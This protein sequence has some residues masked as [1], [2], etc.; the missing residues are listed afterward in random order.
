M[1]LRVQGASEN[2]VNKWAD[3]L[4][5]GTIREAVIEPVGIP[6]FPNQFTVLVYFKKSALHP[7]GYKGMPVFESMRS[8]Y[9]G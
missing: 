3:G 5:Y 6:V 7:L 9:K 4:C 2:P 8:G 1:I